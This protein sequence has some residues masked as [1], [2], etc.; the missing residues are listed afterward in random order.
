[1]TANHDPIPTIDLT[2]APLGEMAAE[3]LVAAVLAHGDLAE[4]HYLELKGPPDLGSKTAIA[5]VAKFILGAANRL[6]DR[7]A[8]AFG[9]YAVMIVGITEN[10]V[11]GVPPME[12][13][14]LSKVIQ[15]YL[16]AA[17]PRWDIVRIP[18]QDTP[19]QVLI[20]IV[21]PPQKGQPPFACRANGEGLQDGR[22]YYRGDGETREVTAD[23][24]DLL[25]ARGAANSPAPVD[26]EVAVKGAVVPLIV[27]EATLNELVEKVRRRLLDALPAPDPKEPWETGLA[28]G[29]A[30]YL[31]AA[32]GSTS[33]SR[34]RADQLAAN[35]I[36]GIAA[37]EDP[38]SRSEDEYR[39]EI[40]AWG[41][42]FRRAWADAVELFAAHS[43][44]AIEVAV[45]NNTQTFLHD[46]EVKIHLDEPVLVVDALGDEDGPGWDD[47]QLPSPPRKWGPVKRELRFGPAYSANLVNPSSFVPDPYSPS[48]VEWTASDTVSAEIAVGDL[49][50]KAT[51]QTCDGDVVLLVKGHA[52]DQLRGTWTATARGYNE[53]FTGEV[54]LEIADPAYLTGLIREFLDLGES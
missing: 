29:A 36:A 23:E 15:R 19:N 11:E 17:G 10:G 32:M 35:R 30:S 13:L 18:L 14:E 4:D 22:I 7:A 1:M 40:D 41:Q 5:K 52:P 50:P 12:K 26:L 6:P 16:G 33:L 42:R 46:V 8:E 31:S 43:L 49:R 20:F 34:L 54:E 38:E 25:L 53:V 44:P 21:D 2:R 47:L 24:L 48:D 28:A 27:D 37:A 51:F 45:A 3:R 9:G 39:A